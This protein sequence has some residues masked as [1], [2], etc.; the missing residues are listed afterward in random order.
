[1]SSRYVET[2]RITPFAE[3]IEKFAVQDFEEGIIALDIDAP[4]DYFSDGPGEEIMIEG[5]RELAA[6]VAE[7]W[8]LGLFWLYRTGNGV[9]VIFQCKVACWSIVFAILEDTNHCD[10]CWHECGGHALW[11]TV[12]SMVQL[13]VGRKPGRPWDIFPVAGNP[14]REHMPAHVV[15]HE[16]LL[17]QRLPAK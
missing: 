2:R 4:T 7:S 5:V 8:G 16:Q 1:M 15:E 17:A 14:G 11:C 10:S 6:D 3:T 9:H 13:R 12:D